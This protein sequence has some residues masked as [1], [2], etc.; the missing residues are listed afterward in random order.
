MAAALSKLEEIPARL[1]LIFTLVRLAAKGPIPVRDVTIDRD[2]M[3]GAITLTRWFIHEAERAYAML[4]ETD[5]QRKRRNLIDYIQ[6]KGGRVTVRD[7]TR[8]LKRYRRKGSADLAKKDLDDLVKADF[9]RFEQRKPDGAGRSTAVFILNQNHVSK[10]DPVITSLSHGIER[11]KNTPDEDHQEI[12]SQGVISSH[13]E[14]QNTPD[15]SPE[16]F[17]VSSSDLHEGDDEVGVLG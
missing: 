10:P 12:P 1:A 3:V 7:L 4:I 5:G 6:S 17:F 2:S 8:G 16:Q 15:L 11:S 14:G 13:G 9:G